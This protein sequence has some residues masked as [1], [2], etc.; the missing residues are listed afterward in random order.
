MK[1]Q[2]TYKG[3]NIYTY[4]HMLFVKVNININNFKLQQDE[5]SNKIEQ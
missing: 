4:L 3:F 5:K 2:I 1:E